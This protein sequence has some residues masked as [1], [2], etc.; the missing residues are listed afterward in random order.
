MANTVLEQ[1]FTVPSISNLSSEHVHYHLVE[2]YQQFLALK[3]TQAE[4]CRRNM[5]DELKYMG[6]ATVVRDI[7]Y[8]AK[9]LDG[10]LSPM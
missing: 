8:M 2:Q 4:L 5:G 1:G 6:T 10:S 9:A 7:D 3:A